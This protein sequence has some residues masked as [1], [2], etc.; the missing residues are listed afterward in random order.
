MFNEDLYV[1]YLN[2]GRCEYLLTEKDICAGH[3][4][5]LSD[6]KLIYVYA[7]KLDSTKRDFAPKFD[8]AY[9]I[10]LK[11]HEKK[12]LSSYKEEKIRRK[13]QIVPNGVDKFTPYYSYVWS[14][15]NNYYV[16]IKDIFKRQNKVSEF[17]TDKYPKHYYFD[18]DVCLLNKNGDVVGIFPFI[19][20]DQ[21]GMD[22]N[23]METVKDN[24]LLMLNA[25]LSKK[26]DSLNYRYFEEIRC[27]YEIVNDE[28]AINYQTRK[29]DIRSIFDQKNQ[30]PEVVN[31]PVENIN[32]SELSFKITNFVGIGKLNDSRVRLRSAP[33]LS[34]DTLSYLNKGDAVKITDRS[35]DTFTI[36]GESW[37]WYNVTT[38][39]SKT[40]WV[41]GK[42]LDIER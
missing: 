16:A 21:T 2:K 40:G 33:N 34:C 11:T 37:Y 10:N 22:W 29:I 1:I 32:A 28:D 39:D 36:D 18:M 25:N 12:I 4:L 7:K 24:K 42:Y 30:I 31:F 3:V 9:E 23:T 26:I 5:A 15:F 41:Y 19:L 14:E 38:T 8:Y 20:D 17:T 13:N 6:E 27:I 35:D